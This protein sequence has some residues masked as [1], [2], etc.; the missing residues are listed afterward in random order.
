MDY[1]F[2]E[3]SRGRSGICTHLETLS[4]SWKPYSP[5]FWRKHWHSK[6]HTTQHNSPSKAVVFHENLGQHH[7]VHWMERVLPTQQGKACQAHHPHAFT[8]DWGY[9]ITI[10]ILLWRFWSCLIIDCLTLTLTVP[11]SLKHDLLMIQ[12]S[13]AIFTSW[14]RKSLTHSAIH[15]LDTY[16]VT[17]P[18]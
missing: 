14:C 18:P 3:G 1:S 11:L 15:L 10:T 8:I 2:G 17:S 5:C 4:H 6:S 16:I 9:I 7:S 13:P 12:L